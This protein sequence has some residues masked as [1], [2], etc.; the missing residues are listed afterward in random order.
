MVDVPVTFNVV[1]VRVS[2][3]PVSNAAVF[4]VFNNNIKN[5]KQVLFELIENIPEERNNCNCSKT[6]ESGRL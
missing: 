4:E 5:L 6:L 3:E 2:V 1:A